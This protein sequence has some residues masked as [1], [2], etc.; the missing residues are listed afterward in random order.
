MPEILTY[1]PQW[2]SEKQACEWLDVT[3]NTLYKWRTEKGLNW[4][5]LNNR[6]V[7][8][9]RKQI[10]KLLFDNSTYSVGQKTA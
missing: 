3:R 5:N 7:M 9:D 10:E 4:T 8:Y 2:I 6:H 1:Q